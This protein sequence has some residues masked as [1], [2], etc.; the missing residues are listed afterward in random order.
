MITY[1]VTRSG[2]HAVREP[3]GFSLGAAARHIEIF[4]YERAVLR[5]EWGVG[6]VIF[7]DL[8]RFYSTQ[9]REVTELHRRLAATGRVQLLNG[10]GRTLAR[11]GLLRRLREDGLNSFDVYRADEQRTP[12]KF[13]VFLHGERDHLGP[14][15]GLLKD[16]ATLEVALRRLA[17]AG[18]PL[19]NVLVTE[20][21][22]IRSPDG[23]FRK[24]GVYIVGDRVIP[25]HLYFSNHWNVKD[26]RTGIPPEIEEENLFAEEL[27]YL[28]GNPHEAK[29]RSIFECAGIEYGRMDYSLRP[30]GG[31]EVWEINTN[32]VHMVAAVPPGTPRFDEIYAP[33]DGWMHQALM[34]LPDA[35]S[36][37]RFTIEPVRSGFDRP[38]A[39]AAQR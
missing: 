8:E 3:P 31:I 7:S 30:D 4:T 21:S 1:L 27:E 29:L 2:A 15:S 32:P 19:S 22:D 11:Y 5:S 36:N 12:K 28:H 26:P 25:R 6:A 39:R 14:I 10:P 35:R 9:F 34:S 24:Y 20:F 17:D 23:L 16:P 18:V 33:F 37:E 13:P 38:G